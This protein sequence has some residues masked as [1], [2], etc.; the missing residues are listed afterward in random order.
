M[1]LLPR[2]LSTLLCAAVAS[3]HGQILLDNFNRPG[4]NTVGGPWSETES[5]SPVNAIIFSNQL[6]LDGLIFVGREWVWTNATGLYGTTLSANSCELRWAFNMQQSQS[7]PSGFNSGNNGVAF[8]LAGSS[9]NLNGGQGYAVVLGQSGSTDGLRLVRYNNGLDANANLTTLISF[10][11]YGSQALAVRVTYTPGSNLWQMYV[12]SSAGLP[13]IHPSLAATPAGSATDATYTS[14]ALP[15]IG[16]LW[17][18]SFGITGTFFDNIYLPDPCSVL[19]IELL[20]FDAVSQPAAVHLSWSTATERDNDH[21]TIE[22]STDLEHFATIGI[23]PGSGDSQT[24]LD[25]SMDDSAPLGG[26]AYYRLRQTDIDGTDHLVGVVAVD[27]PVR[28]SSFHVVTTP[29][30]ALMVQ[31]PDTPAY[32][33]LTDPQGRVLGSGSSAGS[34]VVPSS[35][36]GTLRGFGVLLLEGADVRTTVRILAMPSEPVLVEDQ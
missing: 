27:R 14:V 26:V 10:G 28:G 12:S 24:V 16:C 23:V 13:F 3:L 29:D 31:G 2:S 11:D 32:W 20:G 9:N 18:H 30:G 7:D 25:Y 15:Y 34:F 4:S 17:N 35:T 21:F 1:A 22:R 36:V 8:V 6:L 33:S 19:P 5:A